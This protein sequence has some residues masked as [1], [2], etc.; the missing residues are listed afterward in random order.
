MTTQDYSQKSYDIWQEMADGWDRERTWLWNSSRHIG[1]W[2]VDALD[3]Q[4]GQTILELAAGTGETGF[5]VAARIEPKGRLISTDFSPNMVETAR[6]E[7]NRLRL[8]NVEHRVLDAQK[9]NLTD[10]SIDGVLCRWGYMLMADPGVAFSET[11]RVLRPKGKLALSVWGDPVKNPWV[12]VPARVISEHTGVPPPSPG[13]PG[14][15]AMADPERTRSLLADAELK[16]VQMDDIEMTWHFAD[17]DAF[18]RFLITMAGAI[19]L[20]IVGLPESEQAQIRRKI[21]EASKPFKTSRGY[22]FLGTSQNT[23]AVA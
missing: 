16:L 15:F 9:M 6:K 4:P 19:A 20:T 17:F 7:S 11:R 22:E 10:D 23:L 2:L 18:W 12:T 3:P 21:E 13:T 1:E 5:G 14:V 8:K